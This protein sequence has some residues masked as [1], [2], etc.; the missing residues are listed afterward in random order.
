M[1]IITDPSGAVVPNAKVT[2]THTATSISYQTMS[3]K[4]GFYQVLQLPIGSYRVTAEA[5]G[6]Q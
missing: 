4:S 6:F 5:P 3:D 2:V 1:G